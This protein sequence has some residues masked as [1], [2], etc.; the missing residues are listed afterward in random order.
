MPDRHLNQ[1]LSAARL[2]RA[3]SSLHVHAAL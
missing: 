2:R 3:R 1:Q